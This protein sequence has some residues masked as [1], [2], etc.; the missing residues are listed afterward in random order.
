MPRAA[1][2]RNTL[3][4]VLDTVPAESTVAKRAL[5][6]AGSNGTAMPICWP[7]LA[8]GA[9]VTSGMPLA[10]RTSLAGRI[11]KWRTMSAASTL[12]TR[13]AIMSLPIRSS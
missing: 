1:S 2:K 5:A 12:P 6:V 11:V 10:A 13:S 9:V 4:T 7:G 8:D 3:T